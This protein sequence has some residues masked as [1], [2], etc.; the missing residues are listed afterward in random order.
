MCVSCPVWS[1]TT[2]PVTVGGIMY[3]YFIKVVPTVYKH[4]NE[5][6]MITN[7]FAVTKHERTVKAT[8]GEHGL[9]GTVHTSMYVGTLSC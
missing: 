5:E 4:I 3:Q 7:Q 2:Y 9:P 6:T 1:V 8:T